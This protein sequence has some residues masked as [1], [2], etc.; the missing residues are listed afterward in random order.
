MKQLANDEVEVPEDLQE[1]MVRSLAPTARL[2]LRDTGEEKVVLEQCWAWHGVPGAD[3]TW[4]PVPVV[5]A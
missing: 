2:R 1:K 3:E 4:I 5:A